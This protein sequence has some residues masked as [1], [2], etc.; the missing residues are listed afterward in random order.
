MSSKTDN[1]LQ[2]ELKQF[3]AALRRIRQHKGMTLEQVSE[4]SGINTGNLS[5]MERGQQGWSHE[6][7]TNIAAALGVRVADLFTEAAKG[8]GGLMVELS[9]SIPLISLSE[10]PLKGDVEVA[11]IAERCKTT[12]DVSD[13][14]FGFR[15]DGDPMTPKFPAGVIVV[16]DPAKHVKSGDFVVA[17]CS[18]GVMFRKLV[19]EG[20][21]RYLQP[22]DPRY[23]VVELKKTDRVIGPAV[24]AILDLNS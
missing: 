14:A 11:A 2:R 19:V 10:V 24:Q 7:L 18:D 5:R 20:G 23:P 8:G 9:H 16:I 17:A 1:V 3:G 6:S 22:L 4:K 21:R 12:A 15:V 13:R